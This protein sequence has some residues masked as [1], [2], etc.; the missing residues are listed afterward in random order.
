M[1]G[2]SDPV[3]VILLPETKEKILEITKQKMEESNI[4]DDRI[5]TAMGTVKR[6]FWVFTIG[7]IL[8]AYA[9]MG[10][11]GSLI[12]AAITKKKPVNPID[13]LDM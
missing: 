2:L 5:E 4:S 6:M 13:Q 7:R 9:I 10:A 3:N 12:G 1:I 11:I 8:L